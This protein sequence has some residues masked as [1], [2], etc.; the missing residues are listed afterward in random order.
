M[1]GHTSGC[2]SVSLSKDG[3]KLFSSGRDKIIRVWGVDEGNHKGWSPEQGYGPM[4]QMTTVQKK[5]HDKALKPL[6]LLSLP[7]D[8]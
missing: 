6:L 3:R 4:I 1:R 2:L 8:R 7:N 5:V